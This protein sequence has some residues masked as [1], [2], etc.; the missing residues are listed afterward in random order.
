MVG[1]FTLTYLTYILHYTVWLSFLIPGFYPVLPATSGNVLKKRRTFSTFCLKL[2]FSILMKM[3]FS[4]P[5]GNCI[6]WRGMLFGVIYF[7]SWSSV[8]FF[9]WCMAAYK[10][11]FFDLQFYLIWS[12]KNFLI[13]L[14]RH[15]NIIFQTIGHT[16]THHF[17]LPLVSWG[18]A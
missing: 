13:H 17:I 4:F 5:A 11:T 10:T 7:I 3:S 15:T 14:P 6:I 12:P 9:S 1:V 16:P 2:Y 8:G 18:I